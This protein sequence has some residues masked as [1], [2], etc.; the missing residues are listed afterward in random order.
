MYSVEK[1]AG[2]GLVIGYQTQELKT[3]Q[4]LRV[5]ITSLQL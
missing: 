1:E 3:K 5:D 2:T 4:T